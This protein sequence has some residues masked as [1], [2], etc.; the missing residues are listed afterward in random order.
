VSQLGALPE[1]QAGG[2]IMQ[3]Q[4]TIKVTPIYGWGWVIAGEPRFSVPEP[5]AMRLDGSD[6]GRWT[7]VVV[8]QGHEFEGR[9]VTLSQRHVEWTGHVNI[10]VQPADP[11][12]KPSHGFGTLAAL[13]SATDSEVKTG[14]RHEM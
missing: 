9:R 1:A 10:E 4:L 13:P 7:G 5:S 12:G 3:C 14:A 2:R 8:D 11:G 6:G